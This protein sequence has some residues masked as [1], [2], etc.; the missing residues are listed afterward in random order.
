VD[1]ESPDELVRGEI[2][3]GQPESRRLEHGQRGELRKEAGRIQRDHASIR[4][5][6]EIVGRPK[7]LGDP[8]RLFLEVDLLL[9]TVRRVSG[10]VQHDRFVAVGEGTLRR[11]GGLAVANT[12]VHEDESSHRGDPNRP[13]G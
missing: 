3:R 11:P 1:G 13:S 2:A 7:S 4:M 5:P 10:P 9:G 8:G 6:T 12:A